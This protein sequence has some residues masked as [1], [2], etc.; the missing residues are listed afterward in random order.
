MV[1]GFRHQSKVI[2]GSSE[3]EKLPNVP[4]SARHDFGE[5]AREE[6]AGM[7]EEG[8]KRSGGK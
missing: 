5:G 6:R 3:D 7:R 2:L 8:R 4:S 1:P